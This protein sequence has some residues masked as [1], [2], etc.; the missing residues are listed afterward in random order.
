MKRSISLLAV[1]LCLLCVLLSACQPETSDTSDDPT[2]GTSAPTGT[3]T[4]TTQQGKDLPEY[5]PGSIKLEPLESDYYRFDRKYR[6]TYY[7]VWGEFSALLSE[8]ENEDY[9]DWFDAHSEENNYGETQNEMLLVSFIKR[10]NIS[11]EE[12]DSA[13][14]KFIANNQ[15]LGCDMTM[16]EY[17]VPN[18]DI[19]Y[20]FDNEI[21]NHYYRYE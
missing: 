19:I 3:P 13:V 17:E 5:Q 18:G 2:T 21:I 16:E 20:T 9:M 12:F 15:E 14:E 6:I 10:Y 1:L 8:D 11:R 4:T 7:R